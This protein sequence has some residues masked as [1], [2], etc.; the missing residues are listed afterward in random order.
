MK[1]YGDNFYIEKAR[2]WM[3]NTG[4][5]NVKYAKEFIKSIIKLKDTTFS[6]NG[7]SVEIN[8]EKVNH[9]K[10]ILYGLKFIK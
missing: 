5:T 1:E 10:D 4:I 3:Q 6:K 7:Q 8:Q 9:C 2:C